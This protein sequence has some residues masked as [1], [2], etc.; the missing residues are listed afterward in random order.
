MQLVGFLQDIQFNIPSTHELDKFYQDLIPSKKIFFMKSI[1]QFFS[2]VIAVNQFTLILV[3]IV[4]KNALF[5]QS[6][7]TYNLFAENDL[8]VSI[9]TTGGEFGL[10]IGLQTSFAGTGTRNLYFRYTGDGYFEISNV[11]KENLSSS[12]YFLTIQNNPRTLDGVNDVLLTKSPSPGEKGLW[13]IE[14]YYNGTYTIKSKSTDI[15]Y[16]AP[17][18]PAASGKLQ[19][20]K[21][22]FGWSFKTITK[23]PSPISQIRV[24][25][26]NLGLSPIH[27][28]DCTRLE[29]GIRFVVK[30]NRTNNIY[31]KATIQYGQSRMPDIKSEHFL[32]FPDATHSDGFNKR[33][34]SKTEFYVNEIDYF[35]DKIDLIK[36]N[37][38][39]T[40]NGQILG[41]HKSGAGQLDYN[42]NLVYDLPRFKKPTLGRN[43]FQLFPNIADKLYMISNTGHVINLDFD[44]IT[45]NSPF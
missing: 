34:L 14:P 9:A 7:G 43:S 1:S 41:C 23:E 40:V 45:L 8:V 31:H 19:A 13:E 21:S 10:P 16:L 36:G 32:F 37:I 22:P 30:N 18:F 3:L 2:R 44:V 39:I 38:S 17:L 25:I 6:T 27:N 5:S 15:G 35:V 24:K 11:K 33:D 12:P 26:S 42:C 29:G 20:R 4:G 28:D